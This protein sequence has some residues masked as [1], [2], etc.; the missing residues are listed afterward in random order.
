MSPDY[1]EGFAMYR[2]YL[3]IAEG[4]QPITAQALSKD[5]MRAYVRYMLGWPSDAPLFHHAVVSV[6]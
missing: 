1:V 6:A 4:M 3:F 5:D 2:T